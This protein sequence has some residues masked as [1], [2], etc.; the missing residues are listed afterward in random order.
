MMR[1]RRDKEKQEGRG[2]GDSAACFLQSKSNTLS[3]PPATPSDKMQLHRTMAS[4]ATPAATS[5]ARTVQ[6]KA[7]FGSSA[8]TKTDGFFN[9]KVKVSRHTGS[10]NRAEVARPVVHACDGVLLLAECRTLTART[11]P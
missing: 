7:L 6:C 1:V 5:R 9:F 10:H 4:G 11:L 2:K 8:A 3:A